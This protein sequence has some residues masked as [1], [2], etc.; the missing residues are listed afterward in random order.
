MRFADDYIVGFEHRSGCASGSSPIFAA[1]SRS[2]P[3]AGTRED[4]ADRVRPVRRRATAERGLGKPETFRFLGFTHICGKTR[5]GRF[6]LKRITDS[7]RLRAKL[8]KVKAELQAAHA[9]AD[10]RAGPVAWPAWFEDTSTTTPCPATSRRSTPSDSTLRGTGIRRF[11][12]AAS[13]AA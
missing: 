3:G 2:S 10:P 1:G 4:A 13:A 12:V 11:G 9:S 6:M 7:K 8:R 5:T